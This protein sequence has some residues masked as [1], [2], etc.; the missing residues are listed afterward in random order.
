MIFPEATAWADAGVPTARHPSQLYAAGLEGLLV[1]AIALAVH[2]RTRRPGLTVGVALVTYS[3]VRVIDEF[4]REPD[5]GY[6]LF[7]GWMSKGQA[8]SVPLLLL[9]L[10]FMQ[11][12]LRNPPDPAAFQA[13]QK[14]KSTH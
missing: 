14:G 7:L 6:E 10:W 12:A 3:I 5:T 13:E 8:Y 2:Y 4:F 9:G 1:F 11:R